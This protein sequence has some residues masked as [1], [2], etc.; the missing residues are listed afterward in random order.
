MV[1][2]TEIFNQDG[3]LACPRRVP[4]F[5]AIESW[6][7]FCLNYWILGVQYCC[8]SVNL[9][10]CNMPVESSWTHQQDDHVHC[11]LLNRNAHKIFLDPWIPGHEAWWGTKLKRAWLPRRTSNEHM[12]SRSSWPSCTLDFSTSGF[13]FWLQRQH[14]QCKIEDSWLVFVIC[15]WVQVAQPLVMWLYPWFFPS[16]VA[17][18]NERKTAEVKTAAS[19]A[20]AAVRMARGC[21]LPWLML[22]KRWIHLD[23]Q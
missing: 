5:I 8:F 18:R 21:S 11:D 3:I 20:G 4:H 2:A 1:Y 13:Y 17:L 14:L 19:L 6:R 22:P 7:W 12:T 15:L 9:G 10:W 16:P 23:Q